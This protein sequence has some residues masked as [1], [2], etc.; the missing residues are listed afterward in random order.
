[1]S[2]GN[3]WT[4]S[5][6]LVVGFGTHSEDNNV[7]A[8]HQSANGV[9][10][11]TAEYTLADLADTFAATNVNPQDARI[12]RGSVIQSA[13]V[14]TL[15]TPT[16]AAGTATL[17]LGLWGVGLATEVV[18]VADGLVAD[19]TITELDTIGSVIQCDGAYIADSATAASTQY[20]VGAVSESDC[21]L[22]PSYETQV[23]TAGKVR[24]VV[25]YIP[26]SGSSGRTL[27]AV[28]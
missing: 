8:V 5:D 20:A 11:L 17:D 10:T 7:S 26:P 24:V 1:M 2:R 6:G 4:N 15:V 3:T 18:D 14:H 28:D 21:V 22:A 9:V 13:Y 27:L 12:P 23:F 16:S 25:N 19:A